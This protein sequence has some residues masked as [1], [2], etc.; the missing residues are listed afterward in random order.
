M[1]GSIE[2]QILEAINKLDTIDQA[3]VFQAF[4]EAA[5]QF[6]NKVDAQLEALITQTSASEAAGALARASAETF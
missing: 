6:Y 1:L 5:A 3:K 2:A 4:D